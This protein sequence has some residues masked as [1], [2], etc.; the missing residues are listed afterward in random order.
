MV[1]VGTRAVLLWL[2]EGPEAAPSRQGIPALG[3]GH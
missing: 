2:G 3:L 1:P